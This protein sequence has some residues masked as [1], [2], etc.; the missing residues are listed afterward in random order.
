MPVVSKSAFYI[1][2]SMYYASIFKSRKISPSEE[3]NNLLLR[4]VSID[5]LQSHIKEIQC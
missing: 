5:V 3:N 1:H 2:A 4:T